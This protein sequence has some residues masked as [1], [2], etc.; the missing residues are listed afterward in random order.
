MALSRELTDLLGIRNPIN[1]DVSFLTLSDQAKDEFYQYI[2]I[3]LVRC[4]QSN[5]ALIERVLAAAS[6]VE[7]SKDVL[8]NAL[9]HFTVRYKKAR[10]N[11]DNVI[12]AVS[13]IIYGADWTDPENIFPTVFDIEW[14]ENP[15]MQ[16]FALIAFLKLLPD[17]LPVKNRTLLLTRALQ[18]LVNYQVID[19]HTMFCAVLLISAGANTEPRSPVCWSKETLSDIL[20]ENSYRDS[21][22]FFLFIKLGCRINNDQVSKA[23]EQFNLAENAKL[24]IY[25][26]LAKFKNSSVAVDDRVKAAFLNQV[27]ATYPLLIPRWLEKFN[28][29]D[30]DDSRNRVLDA[31]FLLTKIDYEDIRLEMD[32]LDKLKAQSD[33]QLFKN[34]LLSFLI[35]IYKAK[36]QSDNSTFNRLPSDLIILIFRELMISLRNDS[37]T[38]KPRGLTSDV[39][40]MEQLIRF[41]AREY[42]QIEESLKLKA[43]LFILQKTR[44]DKPAQTSFSYHLSARAFCRHFKPSVATRR[45]EEEMLS[46][47]RIATAKKCYQ[48][49]AGLFKTPTDLVTTMAMVKSHPA[50]AGVNWNELYQYTL[51][52]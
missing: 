41:V 38:N 44:K 40:S 17:D 21:L 48:S 19:S 14:Y 47:T 5:P 36:S 22:Y 11:L 10:W 39:D 24:S 45:A 52:S 12:S 27:H 1:F 18:A 42:A 16:F 51:Q 2:S 8:T 25:L 26:Q 23:Q 46:A 15:H 30:N 35:I 13:L 7:I 28:L 37:S 3:V 20:F 31:T 4:A 32:F 9:N 43:G 33:D 6:C 49:N 34:K 29:P 50:Y